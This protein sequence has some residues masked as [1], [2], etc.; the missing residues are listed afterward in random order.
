MSV[1]LTIDGPIAHL[2]LNRPEKLN[3][4]G[5]AFWD[6]FAGFVGQIDA[7]PAVRVAVLSGNGRAF[8]AGLDLMEMMPRL[9]RPG[10]GGPDGAK[11]A[12]LH[13]MIER[14]QGTIT[15]VERCRV[16]VIA[17]VHG[18]CVGGGVDLITACDI[19]L[20]AADAVF[21]VRETRL[22]MVADIG[23]LQRLPAIVGPGIARELIYTGRDFD[24]AYAERIGLVN[25]VLP[26][27]AALLEAAFALARE[28]AANPPL[29]VQ[30]CKRVLGEAT[31]SEV[32][33]GL[34]YVAAWNTGHLMSQDLATAATA[35]VTKKTPEFSGR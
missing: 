35:Y 31:R 25:R 24:A 22:A 10:A 9:P 19:R 28:I 34:A 26:D 15:S 3:A 29:A 14:M 30:G 4:L 23:T 16:P 12:A 1:A 6:D 2:A 20:A 8:T 27:Q 11:Q 13:R 33:R 7:D 17:A 18:W 21:S 32:D 5:P